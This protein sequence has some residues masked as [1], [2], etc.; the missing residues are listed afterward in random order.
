MRPHA[1]WKVRIQIRRAVSP[2]R[3]S[4]RDRISP[5]ALFVKVIARISFGLIPQA[6]IRCATR[7]VRTRVLP[8]PAPAITSSGPS[9]CRTASRWAGFRSAR[10][11]SGEATAIASMLAGYLAADQSRARQLGEPAAVERDTDE[12]G[13]RGRDGGEHG[14]DDADRDGVR[15]D[16][17]HERERPDGSA[18]VDARVPGEQRRGVREAGHAHAAERRPEARPD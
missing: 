4:S 14:R 16:V 7:Y 12:G 15:A 2:S 6:E 1:A 8:E 11:R 17:A 13:R 3:A 18:L 9:V 10:Y 5:A